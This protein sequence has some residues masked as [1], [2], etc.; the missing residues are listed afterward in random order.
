MVSTTRNNSKAKQPPQQKQQA[1]P[2]ASKKKKPTPKKAPATPLTASAKKKNLV[3]SAKPVLSADLLSPSNNKKATNYDSDASS[4]TS[5]RR[6][7][8]YFTQKQLVQDI[9]AAG[10]IK[11]F[12][13]GNEHALS[14]LCNNRTEVYG[15][16]GD[17]LRIQIQKKVYR[18]VL[19]D[20]D[21]LYAENVLTKFGV[22]SWAKLRAEQKST[23]T[24]KHEARNWESEISESDSDSEESISESSDSSAK[25]KARKPTVS[26]QKSREERAQEVPAA[27]PPPP[28]ALNVNM[29]TLP[30][31]TCKYVLSMCELALLSFQLTH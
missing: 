27:D 12:K 1:S 21:K 4:S 25:K 26:K 3:A 20:R 24:K 19:L 14:I 15:E 2:S 17:K 29:N 28:V 13:T 8:A 18:W 31:N 9:E 23:P 22:K 10:G 30:R 11:A 7:I 5:S 6:G 16:R